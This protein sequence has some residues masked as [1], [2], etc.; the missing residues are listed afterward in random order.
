[1][2]LALGSTDVAAGEFDKQ[3]KARQSVMQIYSFNLGQ[4][5]AMAKGEIKY[6]AKLA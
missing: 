3:I 6:D 2:A 5:G 1:M 4:L